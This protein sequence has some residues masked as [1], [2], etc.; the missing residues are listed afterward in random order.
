MNENRHDVP[1]I[2]PL[3]PSIRSFEFGFLAV[4]F[5]VREILEIA[6]AALRNRCIMVVWLTTRKGRFVLIY[7]RRSPVQ[8]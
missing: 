7:S 4:G 3:N 2:P 5:G 6:F 8:G 1:L